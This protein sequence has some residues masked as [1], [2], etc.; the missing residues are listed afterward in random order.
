MMKYLQQLTLIALMLLAPSII[1]AQTISYITPD[2]A[3]AGM[4]VVVDI[5]GPNTTGNFGIG[6]AYPI[7]DKVALQTPGDS[8]YVKLG[9][10]VVSWDG[11]FV[12]VMVL[13]EPNAPN[14]LIP[15]VVKKGASESAFTFKI[16]SPINIPPQSGGGVLGGNIGTRSTRGTMIV[17]SLILRNGTYTVSTND[18]DA[19]TPGNQGYLP[20]R[21]LSKGPIRLEIATLDAKGKNGSDG[22][23]GGPGG[24]G[25]GGGAL[26]SGGDGFSGG[27]GVG[28]LPR[29]GGVGTGSIW[30][31]R[32]FHGG[33][34]LNAV[35]GGIGT[36]YGNSGEGNDEGG[37]GGTGH[38]FGQ[39]GSRGVYGLASQAGGYGAGSGG[40]QGQSFPGYVTYAGGGGGYATNGAQGGGSGNNG[41][42]VV[43]N[44]MLVPF[45]GGS[46]GAS[47]NVWYSSG[48]PTG[49]GGGGGGAVEV[50]SFNGIS[51]LGS[52]IDARG[53]NGSDGNNAYPQNGSGGG[54]GSGGAVHVISRD[55][56]TI[57]TPQT[58]AVLNINGGTGGAGYNAGGIG[59]LGRVRLDGRVSSYTGFAN[60]AQYFE[61]TKDY[62]GPV[63]ATVDTANGNVRIKGYGGGWKT[64][65]NY[66]IRINY[67]FPST[68]WQTID[69]PTTVAVGSHTATWTATIPRTTDIFDTT[70]YLVAM[71]R[72]IVLTSNTYTQEPDWVMSHASGMIADLPGIPRIAVIEDTID[73]GKLRV[74]ICKDSTITVNSVGSAQLEV[75]RAGLEGDIIHFVLRTIDSLHIPPG[76]SGNIGIAFCPK[77]T[78]CFESLVRI[79]S[80]DGERLVRMIGCGIRPEI[81]TLSEID[82]GPVRFGTC[83]DTTFTVSNPGTDTLTITQQIFTNTNFSALAPPLPLKVAPKGSAQFTLRY[84]ATASGNETGF[85]TVKSD[86]R[87]ANWPIKLLGRTIRGRIIA[88]DILDFGEVLVGACKDSFIT[89]T[90]IGDDT[91]FVNN[92]P[93]LGSFFT[94]PNNQLPIILAPGESDTLYI[95]FCPIDEIVYEVSDSIRPET[96]TEGRKLTVRGKG[97]KGLLTVPNAIDH[98]CVVR[99]ETIL[100]TLVIE[101]A[102]SARVQSITTSASPVELTIVRPL[103]TQLDV[104]TRDTIIVQ[105]KPTVVG[106]FRGKV[107]VTATGQP[108]LEIP[109]TAHVTVAPTLEYSRR[110][111]QFDT[112]L[113][114]TTKTEC[115]TVMNPSCKPVTITAA[116]LALNEVAFELLGSLLPATLSD[117]G[118]Y[119][120]CIKANSTTSGIYVDT[121]VLTTDLGRLAD[122]VLDARVETIRLK[123]EPEVLDFGTV[124]QNQPPPSQRA[125]LINIS[126][127]PAKIQIPTIQG[128]DAGQF[129][130][131]GSV[132]IL[133]PGDTAFYDVS[134]LATIA[135]THTGYF[136]AYTGEKLDSVL[137][138]GKTEPNIVPPDTIDVIVKA[139]TIFA[140]PGDVIFYPVSIAS[141]IT[142][143]AATTG[144]F[145]V[146]FDPM[147]IDMRGTHV[148][149]ALFASATTVKHSLGDWTVNVENP[150]TASGSGPMIYLHMEILAG[151][152]NEVPVRLSE[153]AFPNSLVRVIEV[154]D[155]LISIQECD[156]TMNISMGSIGTVSA[157]RPNPARDRVDIPVTLHRDA[158][159]RVSVYN[160]LGQIVKTNTA[161]DLKQGEHTIQLDLHGLPQSTYIYQVQCRD[162]EATESHRGNLSI[163]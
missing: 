136:V 140:K 77:D 4:T 47:G 66:A 10:A 109:Y 22:S 133:Q 24:G 78:G 105:F 29:Q 43:G 155:G 50:T 79:N 64:D 32:N 57:A 141:D 146:Q 44:K 143:G 76:K 93:A 152:N 69:V 159:V 131:A 142:G 31:S 8:I 16:V 98:A 74:G 97:V 112:V 55:S 56:I 94:I 111:I 123:L 118:T 137:L 53:G 72:N 65:V 120:F 88:N 107:I 14:R 160:T 35:E 51:I 99:G 144:T 7:G 2:A 113:E 80:N 128:P 92:T 122:V 37:G 23:H 59:G 157:I 130:Y 90:N 73:F 49:H 11:K 106:E 96:P 48:N 108:T 82:F 67:R 117:S 68:G 127:Q 45:A 36:E 70:L 28:P 21:I 60:T 115:V 38:P 42:R 162:K 87:I 145:R 95:R 61:P 63:I 135:G 100:D 20:L 134:Y 41:G 25:G 124:L 86:A 26:R 132:T 62:V 18:P 1:H 89:I 19:G 3:A 39:S 27:G 52:A 40:G 148:V 84:C 119:E 154:N 150:D 161:Q 75:G 33:Y 158:T 114:G 121:L 103:A 15:L 34:T 163:E 6:G 101:N 147:R 139:D 17:D 91:A 126:S 12:Q 54:G 5:I 156:T 9:P 83:K 85:D 138:L 13:I 129:S 58:S 116:S 30:G 81:F 125:W 102:G 104:A 46:A 151:S 149:N 153:V 71:Q 110:L